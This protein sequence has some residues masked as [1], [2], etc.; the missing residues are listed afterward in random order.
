MIKYYCD[1]CGREMDSVEHTFSPLCHIKA[2]LEGRGSHVK[3]VDGKMFPFSG[4][5][6]GHDICTPCYN[7][8]MT[9]AYLKYKEIKTTEVEKD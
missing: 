7:E 6:I 1:C 3:M 5:E 2:E 8:I 9:A 4:R